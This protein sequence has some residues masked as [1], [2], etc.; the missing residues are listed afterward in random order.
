[1]AIRFDLRGL[2]ELLQ[3]GGIISLGHDTDVIKTS[4]YTPAFR[5]NEINTATVVNKI[6]FHQ[7]NAFL[8][9]QLAL[10]HEVVVVE[11]QLQFFVRIVDAELFKM[12]A[13]KYLESEN[14]QNG[15]LHRNSIGLQ[16]QGR[17]DAF[18]NVVEK[19]RVQGFSQSVTALICFFSCFWLHH[20]VCSS[21]DHPFTNS[22]L[23]SVGINPQQLRNS[24][25]VTISLHNS[26]TIRIFR[27]P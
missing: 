20:N 3:E 26:V 10:K 22:F 17:V 18:Y 7:L 25:Q 11:V 23:H 1:M 12:I 16:F 19:F 8:G 14:I 4:L 15:N 9:I 21:C 27:N 5:L 24:L 6:R 2:N 13:L